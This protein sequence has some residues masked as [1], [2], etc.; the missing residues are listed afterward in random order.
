MT[1]SPPQT[2]SLLIGESPED[3]A[4]KQRL[5]VG[6]VKEGRRVALTP[7]SVTAL[8]VAGLDVVIET[9]AGAGAWFSDDA[10]AEAGA[11]I[12]SSDEVIPRSDVLLMVGRPSTDLISA[13]RTSHTVIGMLQP[14]VEPGLARTLGDRGVTA[15][16]LDGLPRTLS[17]AQSMDALTSQANIAGYRAALVAAENYSRYFPMMITASGTARPADVLVL[18]AGVAGLQAMGTARRLGAVVTG[19]DVRPETKGQVESVGAR[20]LVLESVASGAG[21]GG[22][23]RAL[24]EDEQRAQQ[25]ELNRHMSHRDVVITTAQVPGRR[26]PLLVTADAVKSMRAGAVIIDMGASALGGNVEGSVPD[27]TIVTDNGVTVVG[28]GNLAATAPA[29]ASAAYAHNICALLLHLLQ[30][31]VLTIDLDDQIQAGV[32]ISHAGQ[33]VHPP[34]VALLEEHANRAGGL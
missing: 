17:R 19:Y 33:V 31:G 15:V 25:Q 3:S 23:A 6:V 27:Q 16:S 28:A 20:C 1:T 12:V 21:E 9:G 11:E 30:D 32:V 2:T 18:G 29:A 4:A 14:L 5:V 13:L 8:R 26:P 7:E 34:T 24:S 10:Y 22:Y